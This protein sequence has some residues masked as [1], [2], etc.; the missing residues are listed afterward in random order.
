VR[1]YYDRLR[2]ARQA[3]QGR[4]VAAHAKLLIA[5]YTVATSP[6]FIS[7]HGRRAAMKKTLDRRHGISVPKPAELLDID[8]LKRFVDAIDEDL[9]HEE[10]SSA[11]RNSPARR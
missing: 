9:H 5:V 4:L 7:R 10:P 2:E 11:S 1:A 3:A 6:A 8:G